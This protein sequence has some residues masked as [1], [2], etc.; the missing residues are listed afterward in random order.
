MTQRKPIEQVLISIEENWGSSITLVEYCGYINGKSKLHCNVC[1]KDWEARLSLVIRKNNKRGC[2]ACGLK[3]LA[4]NKRLKYDDVKSHI[5]SF[6]CELLSEEY[7]GNHE[8]LKI[9]YPCG[10][11]CNTVYSN[12]KRGTRCRI[13]GHKGTENKVRRSVETVVNKLIERNLTFVCFN[14]G[15]YRNGLSKITYICNNCDRQITWDVEQIFYGKVVCK[16]CYIEDVSKKL[17]GSGGPNWQG[18]ITAIRKYLADAIRPWKRS[19]SKTNDFLCVVTGLP[20]EC[21]HHLVSFS[22]IFKESIKNCELNINT[23]SKAMDITEEELNKLIHEVIRL[24]EFYG[25]GV[26]LTT[27]IHRLFHKLYGSDGK[28]TPSH[29]EEFLSR[30]KSGEIIISNQGE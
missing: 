2:P 8:K 20:M 19:S 24:H 12:F 22:N 23:R 29:F 21:V 1:G 10:H 17:S 14:D 5:E 4:D 7:F 18:G 3:R 16:D 30:I 28:T 27:K 25:P 9:K 13:C 15:E 11:I 26:P 6:G